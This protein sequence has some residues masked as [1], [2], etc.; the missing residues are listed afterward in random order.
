MGM[1]NEH[2]SIG[3]K[4]IRANDGP[5]MSKEFLREHMHRTMF[6]K[7][8]KRDRTEEHF[9]ACRKQRNKCVKLLRK[10]K[11]EYYGNTNLENLSDTHRFWKNCKDT[12]FR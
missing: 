5:F 11:Y 6:L 1:L 12:F 3:K 10:A 9:N 2:A 8:Y 7:K 4:Y